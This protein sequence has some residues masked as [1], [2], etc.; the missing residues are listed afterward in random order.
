MSTKDRQKMARLVFEFV[1][2][3]IICRIIQFFF[4]IL[5]R[6][7]TLES[8]AVPTVKANVSIKH[9]KMWFHQKDDK[10][11]IVSRWPI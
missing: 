10:I 6:E 2:L 5:L 8:K 1:C 4:L 7:T 3:F 11:D 9:K